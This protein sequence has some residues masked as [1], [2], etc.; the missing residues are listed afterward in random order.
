MY[1]YTNHHTSQQSQ[2]HVRWVRRHALISLQ[3]T[4][5]GHID[6]GHVGHNQLAW[7]PRLGTKSITSVAYLRYLRA[8]HP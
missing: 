1:S 4:H 6:I 3:T 2:R 5:V 8:C 7:I